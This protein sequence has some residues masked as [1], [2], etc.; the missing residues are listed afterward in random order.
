M[1][2]IYFDGGANPNPGT[3]Y[4][5]WSIEG[6]STVPGFV[7]RGSWLDKIGDSHTNNEAEYITLIKALEMLLLRSK[8]VQ[9]PVQIFSDSNLLVE[10]INGRWKVKHHNIRPLRA[11]AHE[12]LS[13]INNWTASWNPREVNVEEFGH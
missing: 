8:P 7:Q 5:S 1:I 12:L 6:A 11:K 10:Q 9:E 4:G 2:K 13:Y 3:G